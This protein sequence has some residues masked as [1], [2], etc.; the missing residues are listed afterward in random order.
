MIYF[1]ILV[2][3]TG[4][5]A[6]LHI[7][8]VTLGLATISQ[9]AIGVTVTAPYIPDDQVYLMTVKP[10]M[11]P[12]GKVIPETREPASGQGS[13][14]DAEEDE[15]EEAEE[16]KEVAEELKNPPEN[17]HELDENIVSDNEED[18]QQTENVDTLHYADQIDPKPEVTPSRSE[19]V[20]TGASRERTID[21]EQATSNSSTRWRCSALWTACV[22]ALFASL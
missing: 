18:Y 1:Q 7:H 22:I 8:D 9:S 17:K 15:E 21:S 13:M 19:D 2:N 6:P 11:T 20:K 3:Y 5:P 12:Q 4:E 16:A 14:E 10:G